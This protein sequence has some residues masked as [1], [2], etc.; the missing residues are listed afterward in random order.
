MKYELPKKKALIEVEGKER[1]AFAAPKD[2]N[3]GRRPGLVG[4]A[5]IPPAGGA[6]YSAFNKPK[7]QAL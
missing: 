4:C 1:G 6:R 2:L 7:E 3:A 5:S